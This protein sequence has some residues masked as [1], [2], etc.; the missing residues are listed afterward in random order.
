MSSSIKATIIEN[1]NGVVT[2]PGGFTTG[3]VRCGIKKSG[4]F[5]LGILYSK[6]PCNAAGVQCAWME[7]C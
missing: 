5:D 6:M 2:S 7:R 1:Q 3:A 4:D